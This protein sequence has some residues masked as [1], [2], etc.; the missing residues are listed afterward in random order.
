MRVATESG[1]VA[2]RV[3]ARAGRVGQFIDTGQLIFCFSSPVILR[4]M[5]FMITQSLVARLCDELDWD[6]AQGQLEDFR[7]H[8]NLIRLLIIYF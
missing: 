6:I 3:V 2:S 5:M 4:N 7:Y 8:F 1:R